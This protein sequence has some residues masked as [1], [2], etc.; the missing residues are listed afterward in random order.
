MRNTWL[1]L[2]VGLLAVALPARL[3]AAEPAQNTNPQHAAQTGHD[4][5]ANDGHGDDA[6][7]EKPVLLSFDPG[8][9]IWAIIVFVALLLVLRGSAWN[10]ILRGLQDREAFIEKSI[11]DAKTEREEAKKLLADYQAQ[12]DKARE[13][14]TAIVEEGRRDADGVRQRMLEDARKEAEELSAR[15][16][17]EIRLAT[18]GAIKELY[19]RTANLAVDVAGQIIRKELSPDDH[20]QLVDEALQKMDSSQQAGMN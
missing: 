19:D 6:H 7:G 9:A 8:T 17:R 10:P 3:H 16:R 15:A 11:N 4:D 13:E 1:C 5:H 20:R 12:L 14:A 18:D 2:I